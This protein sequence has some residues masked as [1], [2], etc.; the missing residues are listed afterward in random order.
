MVNFSKYASIADDWYLY[1]NSGKEYILVAKSLAG[2]KEISNFDMYNSVT[3][4]G[5]H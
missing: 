2:T 1:D 4:N 3:K 5:P